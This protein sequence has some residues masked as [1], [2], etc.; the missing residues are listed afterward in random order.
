MTSDIAQSAPVRTLLFK[1]ANDNGFDIAWND[2]GK[3]LCFESSLAPVRIW[4]STFHNAV[5]LCGIS[6]QAVASAIDDLGIPISG[7]LPAE[8]VTAWS[9]NSFAELHKLIRRVFQLSRS[10]PSEPLRL[11][12]ER[13][14]TMP[15]ST[16]AERLV[17][18]RVGQDI[19]RERL[20]DYWDGK[21]AITGLAVPQLLR[22]S[23]IKPWAVCETDEERLDVFNGLLLA[24]H[25]DAAF[26]A[27][28]ISFSDDGKM[29]ASNAFP[30]EGFNLMG[31]DQYAHRR[32]NLT[33]SHS[34][35]LEWHRKHCLLGNS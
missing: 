17:I 18:Q 7:E 31:F 5:L 2:Q 34:N 6:S 26:D 10:L 3:W 19:F 4:L 23:H 14:K 1:A 33:P 13:T 32:I 28:L 24:P 12:R 22:A 8:C 27:G 30:A 25:L 16:E 11:F 15:R 21:C 20:M 35:Y 9:V 29:I